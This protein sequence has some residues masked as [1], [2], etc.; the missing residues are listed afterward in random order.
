MDFNVPAVKWILSHV[1][2]ISLVLIFLTS[3]YQFSDKMRVSD[4]IQ[5]IVTTELTKKAAI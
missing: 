2:T 5:V 1:T 3:C 4:R